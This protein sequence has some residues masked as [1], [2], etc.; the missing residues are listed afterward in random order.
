[1]EELLVQARINLLFHQQNPLQFIILI[2]IV[3]T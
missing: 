2:Y 1:M 3:E